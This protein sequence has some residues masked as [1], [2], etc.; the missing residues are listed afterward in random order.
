[1]T[2]CSRRDTPPAG[3]VDATAVSSTLADG[4]SRLLLPPAS[5]WATLG[6]PPARPASKPLSK[7]DE[8]PRTGIGDWSRSGEFGGHHVLRL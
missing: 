7:S 5:E 4:G 6:R 3:R 8:E 1:M 2:G